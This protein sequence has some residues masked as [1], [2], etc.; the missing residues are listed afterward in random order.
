MEHS[1][2]HQREL[3]Y[4]S[5]KSLIVSVMSGTF[6]FHWERGFCAVLLIC[7]TLV[8]NPSN[9][10][11]EGGNSAGDISSDLRDASS[12]AGDGS[13]GGLQLLLPHPADVLGSPHCVWGSTREAPPCETHSVKPGLSFPPVRECSLR[14]PIFGEEFTSLKNQTSV[15]QSSILPF[16]VEILV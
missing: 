3:W 13:L 16:C 8:Y 15:G 12:M 4:E 6:L 2:I 5:E 11:K 1:H 10:R 14:K 7:V 9:A